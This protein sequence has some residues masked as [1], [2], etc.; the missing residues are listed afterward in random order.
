[1]SNLRSDLS[2]FRLIVTNVEGKEYHFIVREHP[3]VGKIISLLENGKEYGLIDKQIA[4][5]DKFIKSELTNLDYFN[6][7]VLYHTPG[8]IWI[9]MDQFGLHAREATYR[10]VDVIMKLKED[11][12]YI[13]VYEKVKM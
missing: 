8:W 13:D 11:L 6:I 7:D 3:I 10:E 5:K 2:D 9:G 12:Y 4:N 1:M